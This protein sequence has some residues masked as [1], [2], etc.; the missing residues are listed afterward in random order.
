MF[1]SMK[2][3]RRSTIEAFLLGPGSIS[4]ENQPLM[5]Q[6]SLTRMYSDKGTSEINCMRR[7]ARVTSIPL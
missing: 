3:V 5:L 1:N 6:A 4:I 2:V 7:D